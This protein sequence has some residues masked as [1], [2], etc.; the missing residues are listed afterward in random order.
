MNDLSMQGSKKCLEGHFKPS[1]A[2]AIL[3]PAAAE[4]WGYE[5]DHRTSFFGTSWKTERPC[6][7]ISHTGIKN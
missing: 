3:I 2:S 5:M 1:K 7:L 6:H 4:P